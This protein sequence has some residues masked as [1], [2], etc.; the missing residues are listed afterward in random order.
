MD[1]RRKAER[2]ADLNVRLDGWKDTLLGFAPT[3]ASRVPLLRGV[4]GIRSPA[5]RNL[6]LTK[7]MDS[8]T[9]L[10]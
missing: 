6:F 4:G 10:A 5:L 2:T 1:G 7:P 9:R 8:K 3:A